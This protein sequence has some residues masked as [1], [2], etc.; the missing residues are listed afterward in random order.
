[1]WDVSSPTRDQTH[2]S[3]RRWSLNCW[4]AKEV[5]RTC[6]HQLWGDRHRQRQLFLKE[7]FITHYSQEEGPHVDWKNAQHES[8]ELS[9]IWGW[10][11]DCSLRD[12]TSGSSDGLLQR[13]SGR[14]STYKISVKRSSV[15]S[16]TYFTKDILLVTKSWCHCEGI[17]CF[18]RYEEMQGLGSWNQFLKIPNNLKTCSTSFPGAQRASLSTL[19]SLQGVLKVTGFNFSRGR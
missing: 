7:E 17:Q 11:K 9:F 10:N 8:C 1:M 2:T 13:G 6:F 19:S 16:S 5:P 3:L 12:S 14:R 18:S 4:T 15:K